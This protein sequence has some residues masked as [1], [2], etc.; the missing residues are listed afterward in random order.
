MSSFMALM[1]EAIGKY[2]QY[3]QASQSTTGALSVTG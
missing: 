2:M 3:A 1:L